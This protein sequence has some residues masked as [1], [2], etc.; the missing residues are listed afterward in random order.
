MTNEKEIK[1][2]RR[3]I[4]EVLILKAEIASG[5]HPNLVRD[6]TSDPG[7]ILQEIVEAVTAAESNSNA[8]LIAR[9]LIRE[10]ILLVKIRHEAKPWDD[11][12]IAGAEPGAD[13]E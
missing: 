4:S 5:K 7:P 8:G 1:N 13:K 9:G 6:W 12:S 2:E 10:R 11:Q 3:E